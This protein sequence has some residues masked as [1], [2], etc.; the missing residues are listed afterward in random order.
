ML[1]DP[2]QCASPSELSK[3]KLVITKTKKTIDP[4]NIAHPYKIMVTTE[5]IPI[6]PTRYKT[7]LFR[8]KQTKITDLKND[9]FG[10]EDMGQFLTV[11]LFQLE[12]LLR[13]PHQTHCTLEVLYSGN[14]AQYVE[15]YF[16]AGNEVIQVLRKYNLPTEIIGEIGGVLKVSMMFGMVYTIYNQAKKKSF[17]IGSVFSRRKNSRKNQ[18]RERRAHEGRDETRSTEGSNQPQRVRFLPKKQSRR[19]VPAGI[20]QKAEEE[21]FASKTDFPHLI[22]KVNSLDVLERIGLNEYSRKL[23][24]QALLIKR[25]VDKSPI[26]R[27]RLKALIKASN[28]STG[29]E[30]STTIEE[31]ND[32]IKNLI[33]KFIQCQ[34]SQRPQNGVLTKKHEAKTKIWSSGLQEIPEAGEF[35]EK[36]KAK[37]IEKNGIL[38]SRRLVKVERTKNREENSKPKVHSQK[39]S[40]KPDSLL[41]KKQNRYSRPSSQVSGPGQASVGLRV[42]K[43]KFGSSGSLGRRIVFKSRIHRSKI[44]KKSTTKNL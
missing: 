10:L 36:P 7:R 41:K 26:L 11:E 44:Q 14:C 19:M 5:E 9:F 22:K 38:K 43:R 33:K 40:E 6:N 35:I 39:D 20:S 25:F 17:I 8:T 27:E 34:I 37:S 16:E 23:L 12:N 15:F 32:Q 18:I 3:L 30:K 31:K 28:Q 13:P 4:S 42:R 24:P 1:N 29:Q 21:C 2:S